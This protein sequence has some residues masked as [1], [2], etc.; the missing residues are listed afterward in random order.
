MPP[1]AAR[2]RRCALWAGSKLRSRFAQQ[3]GA[4]GVR[5]L[6]DPTLTEGIASKLSAYA[7]FLSGYPFGFER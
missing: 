4:C 7:V 1:A 6:V 2:R 5:A 3:H